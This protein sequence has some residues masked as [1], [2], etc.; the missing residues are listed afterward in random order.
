MH[1]AKAPWSP[2]WPCQKKVIDPLLDPQKSILLNFGGPTYVHKHMP[3]S[4]PC[5]YVYIC[6]YIYITLN[7][8]IP[9]CVYIYIYIFGAFPVFNSSQTQF[10]FIKPGRLQGI[11]RSQVATCPM[12]SMKQPPCEQLLTSKLGEAKSLHNYIYIY[13]IYIYIYIFVIHIYIYIC[14]CNT[15]IYIYVLYIYIYMQLKTLLKQ[16]CTTPRPL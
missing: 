9:I 13:I 6:I 8:Y 11:T 12:L 5:V 16:W 4:I 1:F 2:T 15:Y 3:N 14:I 10:T 7:I